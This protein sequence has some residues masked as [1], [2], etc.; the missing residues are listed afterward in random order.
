[1]RCDR[2]SARCQHPGV[3]VYRFG[4]VGVDIEHPAVRVGSLDRR[5]ERRGRG[6]ITPPGV[7]TASLGKLIRRID[8]AVNE[9]HPWLSRVDCH[10]SEH[11]G[12][13]QLAEATEQR[14]VRHPVDI[15]DAKAVAEPD[16]KLVVNSGQD[17]VEPVDEILAAA[18]RWV[19]N[20][21]TL[22]TTSESDVTQRREGRRAI[23]D[24]LAKVPS[25]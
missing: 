17:G 19:D 2:A 23:S 6:E 22:R 1:M 18:V 9:R 21:M 11:R 16:V 3:E 25:P 14:R 15:A 5:I 8:E 20:A 12:L 7:Q 10:G 13:Q 24:R 4:R